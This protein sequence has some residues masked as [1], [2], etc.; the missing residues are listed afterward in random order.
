MRIKKIIKLIIILILLIIL[1]TFIIKLFIKKY[2][3]MY[4]KNKYIVNEVYKYEKNKHNYEINIKSKKNE[5]SYLLNKN[6]NKKKKIIKD[7]KIYEENEIMCILPI[8]IKNIDLKL[9][10]LENNEQVSNFYLKD[11]KSYQN[12]LNKVEK[13]NIKNNAIS[14]NT[15]K[16]KNLKIYNNNIDKEDIFTVWDYK[17]INVITK[18]EVKYIKILDYDLYDNLKSIIYDKYFVLFENN[19]VEGIKNI[20]YYDLIKD[21]LKIY[22]P[23]IIIAK[24]FYINGIIDN[25][26]YVTDNK[27]EKQYTINLKRKKIE[28]IS[29]P[30]EYYIYQEKKLSS[31]T[32]IDFFAEEQLFNN[33]RIKNKKITKDEYIKENSIYYFIEEDNFYRQI[34]GR[35]KELLF[36]LKDIKEW[37]I[38]ED[39]ILLI[40]ND[41][42]YLYKD[43]NGLKPI[44]KSNELKYNYKNICDYKEKK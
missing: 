25:L 30:N 16:Y 12:I 32:K 6:F 37:K 38:I 28:Q 23:K 2:D 7:I 5:V 8:Y 14:K 1:S 40:S 41:T 24:D 29:K 13:Y 36:N 21:K 42:L 44:V 19:K 9:Y 27:E 20:Y 22:N 15:K 17:G 26:I 39:K 10:C 4:E 18:D 11:N 35:K 31:L 3:I 43:E 33:R 34:E